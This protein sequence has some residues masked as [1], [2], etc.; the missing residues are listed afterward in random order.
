MDADR[1]DGLVR[2]VS[3][4]VSRRQ[5]LA[6]LL[7]A[8]VAG[9]LGRSD[10][11]AKA[12]R[13]H[14]RRRIQAQDDTPKPTGKKCTKD[15]QCLSGFCDRDERDKHGTCQEQPCT[16]DCTVATCSTQLVSTGPPVQGTLTV[17]DTGSGLASILVTQS[18]N[19][20]T[21]VP[22]FTEGTTA[23][24]VASIT[25]I[26]QT[27]PADITLRVTDVAGNVTTCV[28]T[29]PCAPGGCGTP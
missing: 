24:V 3:Q 9:S 28:A 10:A 14:H 25:T 18:E 21:I 15:E 23:A 19:A 7:G 13:Q 11:P 26:D 22:P 12:K 8:T 4:G 1:F 2:R 29:L 20:D 17:Q 6:G 27:K 5:L 16:G